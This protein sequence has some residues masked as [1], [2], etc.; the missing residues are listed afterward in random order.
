MTLQTDRRPKIALVVDIEGW[1]FHNIARQLQ[2][3]LFDRFHIEIFS[4]ESLGGVHR[5]LLLTRDFD[6]VHFFWRVHLL[7]LQS[8]ETAEKLAMLGIDAS[9]ALADYRCDTAIT[10]SVYDHLFLDESARRS[11]LAEAMQ[12]LVGY[13]VSSRRLLSLYAQSGDYPAPSAVL[14]DGV[15]L[16]LFTPRKLE[17]FCEPAGRPLTVGWVGNSAW[18]A[19]TEDFKGVNTLLRPVIA[20]LQREGMPIELKLADRQVAFIAHRDMPAFY[21]GVDLYVCVSKIE[22]TPNPVLEAMACGVPVVSTNVGVVPEVFGPGQREL[23][24]EQWSAEALEA[25]LRRVLADRP[26]LKALSDE[27]ARSIANWDWKLKAEAFGDFFE[28]SLS[29]FRKER[30]LAIPARVDQNICGKA[31]R[32]LTRPATVE[33]PITAQ[34]LKEN[35]VVCMLFYNKLE[36]TIESIESFLDAGVR[37]NILDNGSEESAARRMRAHF[38][39]N[40]LVDI[41]DAGRNA[42]VSG[43]RNMQLGA[44]RAPWLF[45]VDNDISIKTPDWLQTLADAMATNPHADIFAPRLFNKHEDAWGSMSDFVVDSHGSCAFVA[46]SSEFSNAFPGGASVISRSV[47]ERLGPYD[48]DLFV[49]FED[50]ELAIRAWRRGRPLFVQHVGG[51]V[52]IHDHRVSHAEADKET[53]RVRYD[54]GHISHS[55]AVVRQK[56]G[57]L[58]DPNFEDWLN[59]QVT[60]LTGESY[61]VKVERE[62][63][64]AHAL[65][66][67]TVRPRYCGNAVRLVVLVDGSRA[68]AWH[69]LRSAVQAAQQARSSG[70]DVSLH[71]VGASEARVRNAVAAGL[72]S[73][74]EAAA[75][76]RGACDWQ[77]FHAV[78]CLTAGLMS[79][80]FLAQLAQRLLVADGDELRVYLPERTLYVSR[81]GAGAQLRRTGSVDLWGPASLTPLAP[82]FAFPAQLVL[83]IG[84][85]LSASFSDAASRW[86]T[87][88]VAKG[89]SA[90]AMLESAAVVALDHDTAHAMHALVGHMNGDTPLKPQHSVWMEL[91]QENL[92]L[93]ALHQDIAATNW[94]ALPV[95]V[96]HQRAIVNPALHPVLNKLLDARIDHVL[97]VPWL[98]RGGADRAALAYLRVLQARFPGRVLLITTEPAESYWISQIP[99]GLVSLQWASVANWHSSAEARQALAWMLVR[100][101]PA[102]IHVMNS[103]LGWE[104]LATDGARLRAISRTFASLFWYGPSDAW[105]LRGY[106]ADYVARLEESGA[107]DLYITDNAAF[108]RQLQK[109]L[110]LDSDR[111]HCVWHPTT[112]I[113]ATA[114]RSP[115]GTRP[116]VMWA[117]R[118]A[119]EKRLDLLIQIAKACPDFLFSVYG[120][121]DALDA[122]L[123]AFQESLSALGNVVLGGAFDNFSQLPLDSHDLFLYTS[124]SDGMPNVVIEAMA[125]GLPVVSAIVGGVGDL[126]DETTAWPVHDIHD[127]AAYVTAMRSALAD[128]D[129]RWSRATRGLALIQERHT[130]DAFARQLKQ[131]PGYLL[132]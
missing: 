114:D 132:R 126:I 51:I 92:R 1:A 33:R 97:I 7:D 115:P 36:Q 73:D 14:Q 5:V 77:A 17:R 48:E 16:A 107:V 21:E 94:S 105:Q 61:A 11:E 58:L 88:L 78:C 26:M 42:G 104:M 62:G 103:W 130:L 76:L 50:F 55:H 116:R 53:A 69:S 67:A 131:V 65:R 52:L 4:V 112:E 110:G 85:D 24:L 118:F 111:F 57:V 19:G 87:R 72:L 25:A 95:G 128:G 44:T 54:T 35:L 46:T 113:V 9:R 123:L 18:S 109:D 39:A 86:L 23:I 59:E 79:S 68:Q 117:S 121:A 75:S 31:A 80:D 120:D 29:K 38:N 98:R 3:R 93:I 49:G 13:S 106:A 127:P 40:P 125:R 30:P 82:L 43:G 66:G 2:Q 32:S 15:D 41:V 102:C 8:A 83:A 122:K 119:A 34:W 90:H 108:P 27:N 81:A 70:V 12:R 60:Q 20:K 91:E 124:S 99:E 100:L 37:V 10:S 22:G 74:E 64:L 96:Q 47:F 71:M 6:L 84:D 45:Y 101:S 28:M 56:H 89:Y 63:R 129:G